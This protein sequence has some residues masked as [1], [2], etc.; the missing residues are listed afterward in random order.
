MSSFTPII[1]FLLIT[2]LFLVGPSAADTPWTRLSS[3]H[4]DYR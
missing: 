2:Y 1:E 3:I 4:A